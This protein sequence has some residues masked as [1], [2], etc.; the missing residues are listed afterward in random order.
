M[1]S[2]LRAGTVLPLF[3][4]M[5][6]ILLASAL[7]ESDPR[8][9]LVLMT[10]NVRGYPENTASKRDFFNEALLSIEADILCVQE[11]KDSEVVSDFVNDT[12]YARYAFTDIEEDGQD[13]AV[14]VMSDVY[15]NDYRAV[16]PIG[17]QHHPKAVYVAYEG[18]DAVLINV[19]LAYTDTA[20]R[21]QEWGLLA[22]FA[23]RAMEIDPDVIIAGDVNTE[24]NE[25][26][27][28]VENLA[29]TLGFHVLSPMGPNATPTNYGQTPHW[30]DH[31]LVSP[32]LFTEEAIAAW[33]VLFA[34]REIA[35]GVSDHKPVVGLF[36]TSP[37]YRDR[38]TE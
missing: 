16:D 7:A 18:F 15:M 33:T 6:F 36:R 24:E 21:R 19:H 13:N 38:K 27:D 12:D 29:S 3:F 34:D 26:W 37:G 35:N 28:T 14:F 9:E 23:N 22:D 5:S 17:F 31:I 20:K 4:L 2:V 8:Q 10:W 1:R 30:F 11:I 25:S 32:D